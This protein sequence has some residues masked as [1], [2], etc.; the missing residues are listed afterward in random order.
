MMCVE[1][2]FDFFILGK[3]ATAS[4]LVVPR[5]TVA[6]Q[7]KAIRSGSLGEPTGA[8]DWSNEYHMTRK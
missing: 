8:A 7:P 2:C 5:S 3:Q 1:C 4:G 6:Y